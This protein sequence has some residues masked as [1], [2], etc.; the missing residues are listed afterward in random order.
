MKISLASPED[1]S[2]ENIDRA[3]SKRQSYFLRVKAS[4]WMV[5]SSTVLVG[6]RLPKISFVRR[7]AKPFIRRRSRSKPSGWPCFMGRPSA[8]VQMAKSESG[9]SLRNLK[10]ANTSAVR[11]CRGVP[12][13]PQRWAPPRASHALKVFER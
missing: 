3:D 10:S 4:S 8:R 9:F 1:R 13:R 5:W 6:N 7:S 2:E 11:F 12:V